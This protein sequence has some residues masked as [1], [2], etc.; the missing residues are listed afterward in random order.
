MYNRYIRNDQGR[1]TRVQEEERA[2]NAG[3]LTEEEKKK[4]SKMVGDMTLFMLEGRS[5]GYMSEKLHLPPSM[6]KSNIDETLRVFRN[7]VGRWRY[8]KILFVK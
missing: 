4:V 5:I 1:Y 6:I 7:R 8:F 2:E 3:K